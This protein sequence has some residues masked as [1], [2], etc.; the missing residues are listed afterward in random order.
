MAR[1]R[2]VL[3]SAPVSPHLASLWLRALFSPRL[4]LCFV[5]LHLA[6]AIC[7]TFGPLPFVP[8]SLSG[9]AFARHGGPPLLGGQFTYGLSVCFPPRLSR[10]APVLAC[11][12]PSLGGNS[13]RPSSFSSFSP[14]PD[15][16]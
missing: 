11:A 14:E 15:W 1:G 7:F 8:F 2:G 3:L 4:A 12:C 10:L 13:P 5:R 9:E 6:F 16:A